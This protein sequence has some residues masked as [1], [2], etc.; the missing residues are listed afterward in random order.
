MNGLITF[1]NGHRLFS[2]TLGGVY[3]V[4][5]V[6]LHDRVSRISVW[7][8]E[9]LTISV[10]NDGLAI[11][12]VVL[13]ALFFFYMV[14][15]IMKGD[16]RTFKA[17]Y[18][19]ITLV[20]VTVAF[21]TLLTINAEYVHF[22]QYAILTV[23]IFA[24]TLKYGETVFW[25]TLLGALDEAYQYFILY[26]DFRYFDF[27]DVILNLLGGGMCSILILVTFDR[28][29]LRM[30]QLRPAS[31]GR[32]RHRVA[33][34]S[35][36]LLSG[37]LISYVSGL[38]RLYPDPESGGKFIVLNRG[39]AH[40]SFWNRVDWGKTLHILHPA[41]GTVLAGLLVGLYSLIDYRDGKKA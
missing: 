3:Y 24:L 16:D 5:T 1:L 9:K 14:S 36:V 39:P 12:G 4:A 31:G 25:V 34:A 2:V 17:L 32:S 6:L 18:L 13:I 23:P 10:Y 20:L 41:E 15:R 19:L 35:M 21:H 28:S 22:F 11:I 30:L 7:F 27:N 38:V 29:A 40:S 26:P 33:I 8:Q 37:F